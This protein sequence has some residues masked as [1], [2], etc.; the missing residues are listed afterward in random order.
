MTQM[1]EWYRDKVTYNN[2]FIF[3]IPA[4]SDEYVTYQTINSLIEEYNV[5]WAYAKDEEEVRKLMTN[6]SKGRSLR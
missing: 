1:N 4:G 5:K 2:G 3:N 6:L